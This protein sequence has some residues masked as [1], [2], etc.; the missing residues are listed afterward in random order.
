[1]SRFRL[2]NCCFLYI[3]LMFMMVNCDF[4]VDSNQRERERG[5][6]SS[7]QAQRSPRVEPLAR[8]AASQSLPR[9]GR[10]DLA[11]LVEGGG[12]RLSPRAGGSG[13]GERAGNDA[14]CLCHG[15]YSFRLAFGEPPSSRGRRCLAA[16]R[17]GGFNSRT[18]QA[19]WNQSEEEPLYHFWW[20]EVVVRIL[21][22]P[23]LEFPVN[24]VPP[25]RSQYAAVIPIRSCPSSQLIV[26]R[27]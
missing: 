9:R 7:G 10:L 27:A 26:C 16:L 14:R 19:D 5:F 12:T 20:L 21:S 22:S 18:M 11:S 1:V 2:T 25:H 13:C 3:F 6:A 24:G 4:Q 23:S 17:A 8:S 15:R